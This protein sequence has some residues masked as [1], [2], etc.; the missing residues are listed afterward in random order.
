MLLEKYIFEPSD[1]EIVWRNSGITTPATKG[2]E[3]DTP[4]L[5]LKVSLVD[6]GHGV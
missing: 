5:P 4:H 1:K 6:P 3:R 2:R